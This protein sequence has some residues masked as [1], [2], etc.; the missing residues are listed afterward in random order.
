MAQA[1]KL[2][3]DK[4]KPSQED[5]LFKAFLAEPSTLTSTALYKK[6]ALLARKI[7]SKTYGKADEDVVTDAVADAFLKAHTHTGK[8][9]VRNWFAKIVLNHAR[10]AFRKQ[11]VRRKFELPL[12]AGREVAR[13]ELDIETRLT[14]RGL[15]AGLSEEER[16]LLEARS[17]GVSCCEFGKRTGTAERTIRYRWDRLKKRLQQEL[18]GGTKPICK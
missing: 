1:V 16:S 9:S 10:M 6:L 15:V 13:Q 12:E 11:V 8:A 2:N 3:L 17:E 5:V 4:T 18:E 14:L 7:L